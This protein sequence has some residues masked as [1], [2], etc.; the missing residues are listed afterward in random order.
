MSSKAAVLGTDRHHAVVQFVDRRQQTTHPSHVVPVGGA[1][2]CPTLHLGDHVLVRVRSKGGG[3]HPTSDGS[4]DYYIPGTVQVLPSNPR[5]GHALHSISVFN[6]MSITS[7][8]RG[9]VKI[10]ESRYSRA[11]EFI[12][13]KRAEEGEGAQSDEGQKSQVSHE[14]ME[15][16][17]SDEEQKSQTSIPSGEQ[18][19]RESPLQIV[20]SHST[21]HDKPNHHCHDEPNHH[22][23]GGDEVDEGTTGEGGGTGGKEEILSVLGHQSEQLGEHQS[24]IAALQEQQKHLEEQLAHTKTEDTEAAP[25]LT[26]APESHH[27]TS[28]PEL[29]VEV[30]DCC[31]QG[32]NTDPCFEDRGVGTGP[33][34]ESQCVGTEWSES[35]DD[36]TVSRHTSPLHTSTPQPSPQNE[37]TMADPS[38]S[39]SHS[40]MHPSHLH[41]LDPLIGQQVLARWPDDGWYYRGQNSLNKYT[42]T[43]IHTCTYTHRSSGTVC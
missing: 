20:D 27:L 42:Q 40:T 2:P 33:W 10:S 31:D 3:L 12:Q 4:C 29:E 34:M 25:D 14:E 32:V 28:A 18:S 30:L 43:D 8:R 23:Q 1:G 39:P 13:S 9:I 21:G 7:A 36:E 22:C 19:N 11:C 16:Q 6:S 35:S 5:R 38:F 17:V 37:V 41:S 15:S 26:S 24:A